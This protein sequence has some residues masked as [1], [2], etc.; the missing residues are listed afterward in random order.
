M[1][2]TDWTYVFACFLL[3]VTV[4][5]SVWAI[6]IRGTSDVH[7]VRPFFRPCDY[8]SKWF[9]LM[10][11]RI[12][13]RWLLTTRFLPRIRSF[14]M[15]LTYWIR[16]IKRSSLLICQ[17]AVSVVIKLSYL[18]WDPLHV[19]INIIN[20]A[21]SPVIGRVI[22]ISHNIGNIWL[23]IR[24]LLCTLT[25]IE[26]SAQFVFVK[27]QPD[28]I[29]DVSSGAYENNDFVWILARHSTTT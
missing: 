4:V 1:D 26:Y 25:R 15:Q 11:F 5:I 7:Y 22:G 6:L 20:A 2:Y 17:L 18:E 13:R 14:D 12:Y 23:K 19:Y 9:C 27:R 24:Y 3:G 29:S 8:I 21:S 16:C 28:N 10:V